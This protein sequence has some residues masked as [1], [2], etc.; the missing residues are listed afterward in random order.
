MSAEGLWSQVHRCGLKSTAGFLNTVQNLLVCQ[1]RG[2]EITV[3]IAVNLPWQSIEKESEVL[4]VVVPT[5]AE[6]WRLR[7]LRH[8][9]HQGGLQ[10]ELQVRT[11]PEHYNPPDTV[12]SPQIF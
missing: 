6:P 3:P 1:S 8:Y 12:T 7:S 10:A 4:V 5:Q 11:H 9:A 2:R